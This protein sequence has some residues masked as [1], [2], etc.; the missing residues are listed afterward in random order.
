M[1]KWPKPAKVH[2]VWFHSFIIVIVSVMGKVTCALA[3]NRR[4]LSIING[5]FCLSAQ[6]KPD[7]LLISLFMNVEKSVFT[8]V[9]QTRT[10]YYGSYGRVL[11]VYTKYEEQIEI[12]K[13]SWV[14]VSSLNWWI[15][16][17]VSVEQLK[18]L[19]L[20]QTRYVSC[21]YSL[22]MHHSRCTIKR[23]SRVWKNRALFI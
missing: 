20:A 9:I 5:Y 22:H 7:C 12:I 4:W 13:P 15:Y 11:N 10:H 17:I 8:Q 1:T 6:Y 14:S 3:F 16:I 23:M 18:T 21:L 2:Y 19:P